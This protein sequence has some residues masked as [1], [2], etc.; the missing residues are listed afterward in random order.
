MSC[1][2]GLLDI[3]D[4]EGN[5]LN[6]AELKVSY[7]FKCLVHLDSPSKLSFLNLPLMNFGRMAFMTTST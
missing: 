1:A 3:K 4:D 5:G 7:S 2:E 6:E